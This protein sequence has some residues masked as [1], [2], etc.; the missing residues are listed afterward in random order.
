[1]YWTINHVGSQD[2][3]DKRRL[4]RGSRMYCVPWKILTD[5]LTPSQ[6]TFPEPYIHELI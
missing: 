3:S 1:M 6:A 5:V 2:W 4:H